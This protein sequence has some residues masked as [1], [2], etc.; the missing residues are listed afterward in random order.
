MEGASDLTVN[1]NLNISSGTSFT[2]LDSG[3]VHSTGNWFKAG[4]FFPGYGTVEFSGSSPDTIKGLA[5][6][7]VTI[8]QYTREAFT[9]GMTFLTGATTGP[10]GDDGYTDASIGFTFSFAGTA[11]TQLRISTNGWVSL[12]QSGT[13]ISDNATLFSTS[14]PNTTLAPW[15]DNLED[16]GSSTVQYKTEGSVPDRVLT[17][18][19]KGVLSY[20][21]GGATARLNFQLKLY[22]TSNVIEFHYGSVQSGSHA[23]NESASIGF[24]DATGGSGHFVEATTGSRT[25]GITDLKSTT[26]WPTVNYRFT[27]PDLSMKFHKLTIDNPGGNVIFE[28]NT[29]VE[30]ELQVS[31]DG[32]F[33]V[34]PGN[35]LDIGGE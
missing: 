9:K 27:P 30:G 11:Y 4:S 17:V 29:K 15:F 19:W 14:S 25:T 35:T 20:A 33:S 2:V 22:E 34:S 13:T 32:S 21:T 12:N 10:T 28:V 6:D 8:D 26:D 18:E 24:E 3:I 1:G 23:N 16:D 31:P 7:E 5:Y